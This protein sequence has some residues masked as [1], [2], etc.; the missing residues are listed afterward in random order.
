[1]FGE[2]TETPP[3]DHYHMTQYANTDAYAVDDDTSAVVTAMHVLP[4]SVVPFQGPLNWT[5]YSVV[6]KL[7]EEC[8]GTWLIHD[9]NMLLSGNARVKI[10]LG[11]SHWV[12]DNIYI[13]LNNIQLW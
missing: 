6:V 4:G 12:C 1:M 2:F 7:T 3:C 5:S 10:V 8:S 13:S 11:D 9:Y